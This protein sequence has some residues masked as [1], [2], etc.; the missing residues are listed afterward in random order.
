EPEVRPLE[1]PMAET[2]ETVN[3]RG[4]KGMTKFWEKFK[5]NLLELFKEEGDKDL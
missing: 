5:N 4:R 2:N 3:T 1:V